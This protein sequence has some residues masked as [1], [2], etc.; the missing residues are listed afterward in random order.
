M[1]NS[2][3]L[4]STVLAVTTFCMLF[5]TSLAQAGQGPSVQ[6]MSP[7][8]QTAFQHLAQ[9]LSTSDVTNIEIVATLTPGNLQIP[10][11]SQMSIVNTSGQQTDSSITPE[12]DSISGVL[13]FVTLTPGMDLGDSAS[14][15]VA[16]ITLPVNWASN[17]VD[18]SLGTGGGNEYNSFYLVEVLLTNKCDT[19]GTLQWE[20]R[21]DSGYKQ[22]IA[23]ITLSTSVPERYLL[24]NLISL[25]P[26]HSASIGSQPIPGETRKLT[27]RLANNW[28]GSSNLTS[29]GFKHFRVYR[30]SIGSTPDSSLPTGTLTPK[31]GTDTLLPTGTLKPQPG[32]D[33]A[34]PTGTLKP[35]PGNDTALPT[36][37][38][39]PRPGN[40]TTLPTGTLKPRP[41]AETSL[42]TGTLKPRPGTDTTLPTGT[43][44]PRSGTDTSLPTGTLKPRPGTDTTLLTGTV[45]PVPTGSGNRGGV[46]LPETDTEVKTQFESGDPDQPVWTGN[47]V[48]DK[49]KEK[50]KSL[51]EQMELER[52]NR[53]IERKQK[54]TQKEQEALEERK[55]KLQKREAEKARLEA[56]N[57]QREAEKAIRKADRKQKALE[58]LVTEDKEQLTKARQSAQLAKD[59]ALAKQEEADKTKA[60]S[61]RLQKTLVETQKI[62]AENKDNKINTNP[63]YRQKGEKK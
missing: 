8:N 25:G 51:Y 61:E 32:S 28:R 13:S 50:Q 4:K 22:E 30:I 56:I 16:C 36:G 34:L 48:H 18:I 20:L 40:D 5:L 1:R 19:I 38:L 24:T 46:F 45:Q 31:P 62:E 41:G 33:T 10:K 7:L 14:N 21:T 23:D 2:H 43:L 55:V 52:K 15:G 59:E 37:T 11:T 60:Y 3:Y 35:R 57:K 58:E 17:R 44:K 29:F 26:L 63:V 54:L 42:P 27:F 39:K 53:K 9:K 6:E 47:S 49:E 12:I